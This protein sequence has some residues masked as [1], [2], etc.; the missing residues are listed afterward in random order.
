VTETNQFLSEVISMSICYLNG[1]Y[2]PLR[3]ACLPV[4]DLAIQRGIGVFDSLRTYGR[5]PFALTPHLERFFASAE[6]VHMTP[7][8]SMDELRRI[9]REGISRMDGD[10]EV[11]VRPYLTGGDENRNGTFPSPRLFVLFEP[12]RRFDDRCYQDGVA[13]LPLPQPRPHPSVKTIDYLA[14]SVAKG[15][16]A[17]FFEALYCPDGE[18]TEAASSSVFLAIEGVLVTAPLSRVLSSITRQVVLTL[19]RESGFSVEE[20]TPRLEELRIAQECFL[21]S[22][23][24][25]V[26]PVIRIGN[27]LVGNGRPGPA[28]RRLHHLFL[29]NVER[30]LD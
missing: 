9:I 27:I 16:R 4:T 3:E 24:K 29:Q 15:G 21:A 5:R 25:E 26:M 20:R 11:L 18:I 22:S 1:T 13:L 10:G 2:V 14:P 7:P 19:A 12:V 6:Q 28:T 23:M 30:W 17:E 8:L